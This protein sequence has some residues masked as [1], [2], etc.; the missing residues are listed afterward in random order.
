[1]PSCNNQ[2]LHFRF[3]P[4]TIPQKEPLRL[5]MLLLILS[6]LFSSVTSLFQNHEHG[7]SSAKKNQSLN[8]SEQ[9]HIPIVPMSEKHTPTVASKNPPSTTVSSKIKD[10]Y[11]MIAIAVR[12]ILRFF[13]A[14]PFSFL[15]ICPGVLYFL[16]KITNEVPAKRIPAT[17]TMMDTIFCAVWFA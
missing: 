10:T 16:F 3:Q 6:L 11:P 1:M 4:D 8:F 2:V 9:M 7:P 5:N 13:M 15:L 17:V 12:K 14:S